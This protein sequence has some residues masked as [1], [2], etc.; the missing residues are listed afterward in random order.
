[1]DEYFHADFYGFIIDSEQGLSFAGKPINLRPKEFKMLLELVKHA[2]KRISKEDLIQ[3]VWNN[4]PAS[5]ENIA[6]CLS[7]LKSTLRQVSPGTESLIKTD[8]GQGYRF[9]GQIGKPAT[10]V[11]EQNFFL[12]INATR[13]L[14]TLKDGQNRWQIANSAAQEICGLTG[15]PWQGKTG[16]ELAEFCDDN[17]R[18]IF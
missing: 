10:F 16:A 3:R 9:I 18:R 17:C 5:D 8:Y 2:G 12:L 14:I 6:R 4:T 15:K 13:N 1:M 7:I 11:N